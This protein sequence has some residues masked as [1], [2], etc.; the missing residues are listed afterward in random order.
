VRQLDPTNGP[1]YPL[2]R[3]M[4]TSTM[5]DS[6]RVLPHLACR[7]RRGGGDLLQNTLTHTL[8]SPCTH[9]HRRAQTCSNPCKCVHRHAQTCANP[10]T[11]VFWRV[12][13]PAPLSLHHQG[14]SHRVHYCPARVH[15]TT[16]TPSLCARTHTHLVHTR[17]ARTLFSPRPSAV[18][19]TSRR[20][21]QHQDP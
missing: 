16:H 21:C 2:C 15:N 1:R 19:P 18:S 7:S 6:M 20:H 12:F 9:T 3:P 10:C 5:T 14:H 17:R 8:S 4:H 11:E 13:P